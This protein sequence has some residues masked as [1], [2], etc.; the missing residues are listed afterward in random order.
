VGRK[1]GDEMQVV[2]IV[3]WPGMST[4]QYDQLV[5]RMGWRDAPPAGGISHAALVDGDDMVFVNLWQ[6]RSAQEAFAAAAMPALE[7][8]GIAPAE[9]ATYDVHNIVTAQGVAH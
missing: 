1:E 6:D 3:R 8:A 5:D 9:M 2:T 7:R 4:A